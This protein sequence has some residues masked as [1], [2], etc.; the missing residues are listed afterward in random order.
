MKI[1]E[2]LLW[3]VIFMNIKKI[4]M[5]SW[6]WIFWNCWRQTQ[7]EHTNDKMFDVDIDGRCRLSSAIM[8]KQAG[9]DLVAKM[10]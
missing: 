1:N 7:D 3:K 10:M 9:A 4:A 8:I 5:C 6:R 2:M